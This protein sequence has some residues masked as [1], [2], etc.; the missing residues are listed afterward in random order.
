MRAG[1]SGGQGVGWGLDLPPRA[2]QESRI[3]HL[4]WVGP[5]A[6]HSFFQARVYLSFLLTPWR[7]AAVQ[8]DVAQP[9]P[10]CSFNKL[11]RSLQ[12]ASLLPPGGQLWEG[13]L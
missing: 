9:V 4:S 7:M 3:S 11:L 13:F 12:D 10:H 6:Q 2:F 5:T 1:L 8:N